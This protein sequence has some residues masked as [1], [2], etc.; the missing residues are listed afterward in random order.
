MNAHWGGALPR[1]S[2]L[3]PV[4]DIASPGPGNT[5]T[6][7]SVPPSLLSCSPLLDNP[8]SRVPLNTAGVRLPSRELG[9]AAPSQEPRAPL[10]STFGDDKIPRGLAQPLLAPL[11]SQG[12]WLTTQGTSNLTNKLRWSRS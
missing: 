7:P 1:G 11:K 4:P 10:F 3:C 5:L 2:G 12:P 8:S 9:L 6:R